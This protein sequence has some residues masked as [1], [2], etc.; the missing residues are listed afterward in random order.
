[1]SNAPLRVA[2]A[3][4]GLRATLCRCG[5][6]KNKPY[7]DNSH[8]EGGFNASGEP[9]IQASQPLVARDGVLVI[10]PQKNGSLKIIGN[11]EVVSG[12]GHTLNRVTETWLCRCGHSQNKPYCDGSHRRAGSR[13]TAP[14]T[15][16]EKKKPR[17]CG[18]FHGALDNDRYLIRPFVDDAA[19]ER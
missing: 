19:E 13:Q 16:A 18:A 2:G 4:E 8:V 1:M 12:T 15:V 11:L 6:S 9:A 7:C 10:E 17:D 5:L 3:D 14:D